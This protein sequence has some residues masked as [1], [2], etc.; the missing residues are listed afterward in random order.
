M[1]NINVG[2]KLHVIERETKENEHMMNEKST[3]KE[4]G[5]KKA[6]K[7]KLTRNELIV[8][9]AQHHADQRATKK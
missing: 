7:L 4:D 8:K 9:V 6:E 5:K 1:S 2:V 3:S